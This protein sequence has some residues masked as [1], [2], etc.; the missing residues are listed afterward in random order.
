M[1]TWTGI[2][3]GGKTEKQGA[4]FFGTENTC[5]VRKTR[6]KK[7]KQ[8][9]YGHSGAGIRLQT[10]EESSA[11]EM[12]KLKDALKLEEGF[13]RLRGNVQRV[14]VICLVQRKT[15]K[16]VSLNNRAKTKSHLSQCRSGDH[17]REM[18]CSR[19]GTGDTRGV[20]KKTSS[21]FRNVISEGRCVPGKKVA[22]PPRNGV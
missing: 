21:S 18:G 9:G 19:K 11:T 2:R 16:R 6:L 12:R 5:D 22:D 17:F 7:P 8:I 3:S 20:P 13:D 15:P 14:K 4:K 1:Q 10:S